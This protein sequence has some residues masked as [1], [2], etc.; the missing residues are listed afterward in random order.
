MK[1]RL[2]LSLTDSKSR[3]WPDRIASLEVSLKHLSICGI[4]MTI[5]RSQG[6]RWVLGFE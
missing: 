2:E 6:H 1:T 4:Y 5:P 3:V